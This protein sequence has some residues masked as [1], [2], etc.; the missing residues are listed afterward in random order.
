M[1]SWPAIKKNHHPTL[2]MQ[3][4]VTIYKTLQYLTYCIWSFYQSFIEMM[5]MWLTTTKMSYQQ[6]FKM[7]VR[8]IIYK[9]HYISTIIKP[10][11]AKFVSRMMTPLPKLSHYCVQ[12]LISLPCITASYIQM[13]PTNQPFILGLGLPLQFSFVSAVK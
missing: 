13:H 12:A 1:V 5:P 4:K 2:K 7:Q 8:V 9:Y 6:T 10:I 3:V 11:L